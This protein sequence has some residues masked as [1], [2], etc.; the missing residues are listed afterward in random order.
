MPTAVGPMGLNTGLSNR[1]RVL[2]GHSTTYLS[3]RALGNYIWREAT[4]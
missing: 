2:M 4:V 1:F 3:M